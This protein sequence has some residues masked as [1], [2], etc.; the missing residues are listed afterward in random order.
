MMKKVILILAVAL[1]ATIGVNAQVR[2]GVKGGVGINNLHFNRDVFQ[3]ENRAS[4]TG[5]VMV[6]IGLPLT[7]LAVDGSVMYTRR[8][9]EYQQEGWKRDYISVPINLKYKICI[10]GVDNVIAPYVFTG[11]EV[12][13]RLG[14]DY[15]EWGSYSSTAATWNVGVGVELV[16]HLQIGAS[17]NI[18]I[19]NRVKEMIDGF[20][21]IS[22]LN[23]KDRCWTV[24][25]ALLF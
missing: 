8:S 13:F 19:N 6:E 21:E 1:M 18:G 14:K 15:D 7:G 17:Y 11:P 9:A 25:A 20:S 3:T 22:S 23:G 12:A 4:F 24:T 5:G 16:K 2:V 10:P